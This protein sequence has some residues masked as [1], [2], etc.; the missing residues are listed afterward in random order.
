MF[1]YL[2]QPFFCCFSIYVKEVVEVGLVQPPDFVKDNAEETEAVQFSINWCKILTHIL[3]L[4][5]HCKKSISYNIESIG[6]YQGPKLN[7]LGLL[8]ES[9]VVC[10]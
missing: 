1:C 9:S 8:L 3:P 6:L 10:C 5:L 4:M 2:F 7:N